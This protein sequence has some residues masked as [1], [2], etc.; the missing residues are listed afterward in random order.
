MKVILLKDVDNLGDKND[1]KNVAPG[2]ARNFLVP[3]GLAVQA[4][5]SEMK[6]LEHRMK[7]E[8][9]KQAKLEEKLVKMAGKIE[10]AVVE[11]TAHAGV[12]GK[13]YGSVSGKHIAEVLTEKMGI[14]IDR[15]RVKM[16]API[17][18]T[19]EFEVVVTLGSGKKANIKVIVS[20]EGGEAEEE[21]TEAAP[22]QPAAEKPISEESG[23]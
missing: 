3:R 13:L 8:Q 4:T 14:E 5:E 18:Q 23:E 2:Y 22:E 11:I 10:S 7:F 17:K 20:A 12:D 16:E 9:R 19:G 1:I 21:K 6:Q 15:K